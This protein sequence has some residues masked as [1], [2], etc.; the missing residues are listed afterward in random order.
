[1]RRNVR[2]SLN[3]SVNFERR[4]CC[5][6]QGEH[7]EAADYFQSTQGREN[8]HRSKYRNDPGQTGEGIDR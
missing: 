3:H 7:Q 8:D 1:M 6:L 2:L 4:Y 5:P